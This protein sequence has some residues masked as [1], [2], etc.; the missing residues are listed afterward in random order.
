[1]LQIF[2]YHIGMRN[3]DY[4]QKSCFGK[5]I[6]YMLC[7]LDLAENMSKKEKRK[8]NLCK[9]EMEFT[10]KRHKRSSRCY[11]NLTKNQQKVL[12]HK[13]SFEVNKNTQQFY[14]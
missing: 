4:L 5:R 1:M 14:D 9:D 3:N 13:L 2:H 8:N 12:I 11:K 7:H 6:L 10:Y